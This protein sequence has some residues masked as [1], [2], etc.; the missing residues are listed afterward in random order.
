[1][2]LSKYGAVEVFDPQKYGAVAL[3][4]EPE[5]Q[6]LNDEHPDLS[7]FQRML[8]MGIAGN[9][10]PEVA[11]RNLEN[12][13]F[14]VR[15]PEG[16]LHLQI[17]KPG[18]P[19]WRR[20]DPQGMDFGDIV[21]IVPDFARAAGST[22][23]TA[24]A[25][26]AAAPSGPVAFFAGMGGGAAGGALVEAGLQGLG[27]MAGLDTSL[28]EA[29]KA[30]AIEG[31]LGAASVPLGT[32]LG[33]GAALAGKGLAAGFRRAVPLTREGIEAKFGDL[34]IESLRQ[35]VRHAPGKVDDVAAGMSESGRRAFGS[36]TTD[37]LARERAALMEA[38]TES[39][40]G[41]KSLAGARESRL[42][43][44]VEGFGD[45]PFKATIREGETGSVPGQLR[46]IEGTTK[47]PPVRGIEEIMAGYEGLPARGEFVEEVAKKTRGERV[48]EAAAA[49]YP[50]MTA[51]G[52]VRALHR[53]LGLGDALAKSFDD[54][55]EEVRRVFPEPE[56]HI[57]RRYLGQRE[58]VEEIAKR[59]GINDVVET[60]AELAEMTFK[61]QPGAIAGTGRMLDPTKGPIMYEPAIGKLPAAARRTGPRSY[62]AAIRQPRYRF[63]SEMEGAGRVTPLAKVAPFEAAGLLLE[64]AGEIADTPR[65][66]LNSLIKRF[67]ELKAGSGFGRAVSFGGPMLGLSGVMGPAVQL[68]TAGVLG[69]SALGATAK[70]IGRLL[71]R[72]PGHII[73][74]LMASTRV[75]PALKAVLQNA[76]MTLQERGPE[77]AQATAFSLLHHPEFRRWLAALG[78]EEALPELAGEE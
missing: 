55:V 27:R 21:D 47:M 3:E 20:V 28:G 22:A 61:A 12:L 49:K 70:G 32:A 64:K 2:D 48:F 58:G 30:S 56:T 40:G 74:R 59:R 7:R 65:Q 33:K 78:E 52:A 71:M 19:A 66:T 14:E 37:A 41:F 23:G 35:M 38:I 53:D 24:M 17:R 75:P 1:M 15:S 8:I 67:V 42:G 60:P 51:A 6:V 29:A 77:A 69:L 72:D 10:G 43:R 18:E 11:A 63:L 31:A 39:Q 46:T 25:A 76:A 13:G 16:G 45:K 26:T 34:P 54:V 36:T 4:D 68:G 62:D 44:I 57:T 9:A 73:S 50:N 5:D